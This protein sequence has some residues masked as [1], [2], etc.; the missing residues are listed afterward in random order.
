MTILYKANETDFTHF[1]LGP[2][3]DAVSILVT[4][5]RNGIF[6][7]EMKYPVS[8]GRFKDLKND[9]IIKADAGH[10]LKDQRFKIIRITK[11]LKGIVTV[12]AEHVSYLSQDLALK[13]KVTFSGNAQQAL[14][15]WKANLIDDNPFIVSSDITTTSGGTWTIDEV[16][17][18]RRALGGVSGSILDKYGGE[19]R[20]DNYQIRLMRQ[21]GV[22]SAA[23]IAY[24]RNLTDLT[25]EEEI[26][27]TY[28]SIYP[29]AVYRDDDGNEHLLT[30]PEFYID[31]E[32]VNNFARRKIL[33]VD[34]SQD[35]IKTVTALR[36]AANTYITANSVGVPKVNLKISYVDLAKTLDYK[37]QA[38]LEEVNLCDNV[39]VYF[40]KFG[41]NTTAKAIKVVWDDIRKHYDSVEIGEARSS[42]SQAINTTVDGRV[43]HVEK[44]VNIIQLQADG[45]KLIYRQVDRP[46][47]GSHVGD[48]WYQ[49]NG[50]YEIMYQWDGSDWKEILNTQDLDAIKREVE[51]AIVQSEEAKQEAE[52]AYADAVAEAGR[53][54]VEQSEAFDAK[55]EI[56]TGVIRNEIEQGYTDAVA[57]A[58]RLVGVQ[59]EAF[60]TQM[61]E[62]NQE[63]NTVKTDINTSISNVNQT[64]ADN[65]TSLS[66][67]ISDVTQEA[68]DNFTA[69]NTSISNVDQKVADNFTSLSDSMSYVN[70]IVEQAKTDAQT[71]ITNAATA[72]SQANS[73]IG[74]AEVA[75]QN[76]LTALGKADNALDGVSNLDIRVDDVEAEV[77]L[78]ADNAFVTEDGV[79]TTISNAITVNATRFSSDMQ[80]IESRVESLSGEINLVILR[81][82][83]EGKALSG[84]EVYPNATA[85]VGSDT[86]R[87]MINVVAGERLAL[88]KD[89]I[90]GNNTWRI[91]YYNNGTYV[92]RITG[93][94]NQYV[95]TV[96]PGVNKMWVSYPSGCRIQIVRGTT[97]VPYR[98]NMADQMTTDEMVLFR[99]EYDEFAD[100]TVRR[101][102]S[103]DSSG[104]RLETAESLLTQ[105]A[106]GLT[107]KADTTTVNAL[108]G[109]VSTAEEQIIAQ[110]GQIAL[111]VTE[112]QAKSMVDTAVDGLE[113]GGRNYVTKKTA[114]TEVINNY[115]FLPRDTSTPNGFRVVGNT[116]STGIVRLLKVITGN[117][118]WT[119]S[120]DIKGNQSIGAGLNVDIC[121]SEITRVTTNTTNTYERRSVS[122]YVTKYTSDVYNFVDFGAIQYANFWID[123]IKVE[124]GNKA[125]D[126][127]AAPE[128]TIQLISS[129]SSELKIEKDNITALLT[130]TSEN[131]TAITQV[132][133]TAD[134]T[135]TTVANHAGRLT[136]VETNVDGLHTAVAD[137]IS[138]SQFTVLSDSVSTVVSNFNNLE[139][140]G[141]NYFTKTHLFE[142]IGNLSNFSPRNVNT[143]NGFLATGNST[144]LGKVRLNNV[145]TSNGWWTVSFDIR[146][147]QSAIVGLSVDICDSVGTR[148]VT[149]NTNT[150]KRV[151][152]TA[153]VTNYS[154]NVFHFV[155]FYNID[156]AYLF[157]RNIKVEKGNRATDWTLAPEDV[158]K[159]ISAVQSNLTVE[160]DK[161]TALTTR[162]SGSETN[163]STVTQ[164]V[165]GITTSVAT[166]RTDVDGK[167]TIVSL[168][169]VKTT[170][171]GNTTTI[172]NHSGRLT[173]V[174]TNVN[175]LQATVADKVSS[176]Q[177]T[178]LSNSVSSV[179][180]DLDNLQVGGRNYFTKNTTA[181]QIV[182][183]ISFS[184]RHAETPNGFRVT[185][186]YSYNGSV[187][188]NDIITG[189]GWWTVSFDIKSD[190]PQQVGMT[191]DICDLG[192]TRVTTNGINTYERKS[193]SVYVTNYGGLYDFVD[194]GAIHYANFWVDNI[195]VEKGNKAT[196]WSPAQEDMATR[197]QIT[198][199]SD[200]INLRVEEG[201]VVSQINIEANRTLISSGKILLDGD[202]YIMGTTFVNDIKAKSLEAVNADIVNLRSKIIVS[203]VIE[204]KYLKV[205]NALI[206]KL[207]VNTAAVDRFFAKTA[208]IN[209]LSV[210][211]LDAIEA[212]ITSI[213]SKVLVAD[214]VTSTHVKAD[215]AMIDNIFGTTALITRLTS[216]TAFINNVKAIE[217]SADKVT[218]GKLNA[219]NVDIINLNVSKIVGLNSEFVQ[220]AWNGINTRISIDATALTASDSAGNQA[221]INT[222]GEIRSTAGGTDKTRGVFHKGRLWFHTTS[223]SAVL[224]IGA[225]PVVGEGVHRGS[226]ATARAE[227]LVIGRYNDYLLVDPNAKVNPYITL[228]YAGALGDESNGFTKVWHNLSMSGKFINDVQQVSGY[229]MAIRSTTGRLTL[230]VTTTGGS[231]YN[232]L[233]VGYANTRSYGNIEMQPGYEVTQASDRRWKDIVG[234]TETNA[235][236]EINKLSVVDYYWKNGDGEK[237]FGLIAQ[238][239][240]FL[241]VI[242][243]DGYYG[244]SGNKL[245]MLNLLSS[246]E[247]CKRIEALEEEIKLL[248]SA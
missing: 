232:T 120:F 165:G 211:T 187:R 179:V 21:R 90:D 76:A 189:N 216:K 146:G 53:L 9:R 46:P 26:A 198:Q 11:P 31:S 71:G 197:S 5:E 30:L 166:L 151:S 200:R 1:G 69:L 181:T 239:S 193:V 87:E 225:H 236:E 183:N 81:D 103:I 164:T 100:K 201:K 203:D 141:R 66:N 95:L 172:A 35:E 8:G 175:G 88:S 58:E 113:L 122:A 160:A 22:N 4:E 190:Q 107:L 206:D 79:L 67:S 2:L 148:V 62:V 182:P 248:K 214:A 52:N 147:D 224:N 142:N 177:F 246:Q 233:Q 149:N 118:W 169:Q 243:E 40:E 48:L 162:V 117:G 168:N 219:T 158:D 152:V 237:Q 59:S 29:Y 102:T 92:S 7:L 111:R 170:A 39:P 185:G 3:N 178:V 86:M 49:P 245:A 154:K 134:G 44:K 51:A 213:R 25:Q 230:G 223:G 101:L 215:D 24:G 42:L 121:D 135:V 82:A 17:N 231:V 222:S 84:N 6:E 161:I 220:S 33:A 138:S 184:F 96:P 60:D 150:F 56:E 188:I 157:V 85:S 218:T 128:D 108:T 241:S 180:T 18:P 167:A 186:N 244:I 125:T 34:F 139:I 195:K 204:A 156:W 77:A 221:I 159:A 93:E 124:K 205:D 50:I 80:R 104:G 23:L 112:T 57:E 199:L 16:E 110:D 171:D 28:T 99:N 54:V 145:I 247:L 238:D 140:G 130:R 109:R 91:S 163:I 133:S 13:P 74:D 73:A 196:D 174:E 61:T 191:V 89:P 15:T 126:W 155:D 38:V 240:P 63:I 129:V 70:T 127:T 209:N 119:V 20:F 114:F 202:T 116:S 106:D 227:K 123:N 98:P 68:L 212:N 194:F 132:K 41:I 210:K 153:N 143:P 83:F 43:S 64:V 144:G 137:K 228:E 94:N 207:T 235:L 27:N 136:T 229:E 78:K 97:F 234:K 131:A 37:N 192:D 45:M 208:V 55:F 72:L 10:N 176:A 226:I 47:N 14:S 173:T 115:Q 65:F 19:Y 242:N 36:S 32:H 75:Q 105:T 217:I 12:H